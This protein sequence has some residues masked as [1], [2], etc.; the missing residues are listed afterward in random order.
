LVS[1]VPA[2]R[3]DPLVNSIPSI[4]QLTADKF[5]EKPKPHDPVVAREQ[6][7]DKEY[8][9]RPYFKSSLFPHFSNRSLIDTFIA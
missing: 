7:F 2:N 8:S 5:T 4:L 9:V 6:V 1:A 3:G